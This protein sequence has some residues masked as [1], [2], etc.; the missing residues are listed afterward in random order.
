MDRVTRPGG[1]VFLQVPELHD[2][3][4]IEGKDPENPHADE[5]EPG[6]LVW[7]KG[8][9]AMVPHH[10]F[11]REELLGLFRDYRTVELHSRTDHYGG[12]CFLARK[13]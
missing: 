1:Y 11:S 6:T 10:Y 7:Y 3:I 9:E 13:A 2:P 12:W 5:V 4:W 8:E